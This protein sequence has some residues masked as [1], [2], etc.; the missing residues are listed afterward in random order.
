MGLL[1]GCWLRGFE[2]AEVVKQVLAKFK[3]V[4][5]RMRR[6][7]RY[8]N[9]FECVGILLAIALCWWLPLICIGSCTV[10]LGS[11]YEASRQS[12]AMGQYALASM[13]SIIVGT[14]LGLGVSAAGI[15]RANRDIRERKRP[16]LAGMRKAPFWMIQLFLW[17]VV[18]FS[19]SARFEELWD[20]GRLVATS[21]ALMGGLTYLKAVLF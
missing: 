18:I 20:I 3:R 13:T 1:G 12:N 2:M 4:E 15:V 7:Q 21:V 8:W 17:G 6:A 10:H 11:W 14:L 9:R 16:R 19:V 5:T